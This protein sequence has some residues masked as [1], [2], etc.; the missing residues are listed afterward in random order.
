MPHIL[1]KHSMNN[2]I[3]FYK[4]TVFERAHPL[5]PQGI[6]FD[7]PFFLLLFWASHNNGDHSQNGRLDSPMLS[8]LAFGVCDRVAVLKVTSV[9]F[10]LMVKS[11]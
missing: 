4:K 3:I 7:S 8:M 2:N 10:W 9:L 1:V 5:P 11:V 6:L